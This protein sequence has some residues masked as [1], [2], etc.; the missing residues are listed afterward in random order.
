MTIEVLENPENLGVITV[1]C[2]VCHTD[3]MCKRDWRMSSKNT[4]RKSGWGVLHSYAY[5]CQTCK[6][7]VVVRYW[8]ATTTEPMFER[9]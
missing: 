3:K 2:K 4:K 1:R 6:N 5:R 7:L 8:Q 9:L